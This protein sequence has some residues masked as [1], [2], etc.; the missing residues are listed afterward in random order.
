MSE[1]VLPSAPARLA[2]VGW[3]A[4]LAAL[5]AIAVAILAI[6]RRDAAAMASTWWH[7]STYEHCLVI[8]PII[9]WLVWQRAPLLKRMEPHAWPL[10]LLWIAI[11]GLGWLV[12]EAAGVSLA[13]QLGLVMML[14]GAV[15]AML[16]RGVTAGLI[17]PLFYAFFL[18]PAGD[19]V[20]PPLQTITAKLCMVF[21]A[22]VH[23]PATIDGVF[24]TT[25]A[26]LFKV[27]EACSGAKFLVAMIALGV[28]VAN[29]GFRSWG[30]R[31]AFMAVCIVV[32]ILANGLRAFGTIWVAQYRGAQ[33]AEGFDH[34]VYGWFFFGAVIAVVL[35]LSWKFFDRPADAPPFDAARAE[36]EVAKQRAVWPLAPAVVAVLL[37]SMVAPVWSRIVATEGASNAYEITLPSPQGWTKVEAGRS[38]RPRFD[39][40]TLLMQG[41]RNAA[42]QQ[43][44]LAIA[45][46]PVQ[47][48]QHSLVGYGHGAV[49]PQGPW[50][51]TSDLPAPTNGRAEQLLAGGQPL[52]TVVSFYNVGGMITGSPARV[53]METLKRRLLGGD[54]HA[55]ALLV[56]ADEAEGGRA[57]VDAFLAGIGPVQ[58]VLKTIAGA[59]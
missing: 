25:P 43:V 35:A 46:L 36:R 40:A 22:A 14:Q 10:P 15:A 44:D 54:R 52:R 16:G 38:W 49:D 59:H 37:V 50:S 20:I 34:V 42:G 57:A 3:R 24:I 8:V 7:S 39:G 30:R 5:G 45:Y 13:R 56:S 48:E 1:A 41:Y 11:G 31:A 23:V 47:D 12:G 32:P 26:G 4:H 51:W 6:F 28:L 9:G 2:F 27:A 55:M 58:P 21:L 53:K 33:A 18:V 17:F 19:G 29:L